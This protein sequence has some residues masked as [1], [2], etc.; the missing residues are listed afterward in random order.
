M[1]LP[2]LYF[3][4][5]ITRARIQ[6]AGMEAENMQRQHLGQS[7]AYVEADFQKVIDENGLNHNQVIN[8]L[9]E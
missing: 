8:R 3:E 2:E 7:M 6:M 5:D 1:N 4:A 9:R